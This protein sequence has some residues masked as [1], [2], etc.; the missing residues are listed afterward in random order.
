MRLILEKLASDDSNLRLE[1]DTLVVQQ[2]GMGSM[3]KM[4]S[5]LSKLSLNPIVVDFD[6]LDFMDLGGIQ[7]LVER[8]QEIKRDNKVFLLIN[9]HRSKIEFNNNL[10]HIKIKYQ[11]FN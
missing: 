5:T 3:A 9:S 10:N 6:S 7:N 8:K 11:P 2:V 1:G 4:Q